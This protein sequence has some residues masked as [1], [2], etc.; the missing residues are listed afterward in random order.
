M[1][2]S[3]E[4]VAT[5]A[6]VCDACE[7]T[8]S[9]LCLAS[10]ASLRTQVATTQ[11]NANG[12]YRFTSTENDLLPGTAYN[13]VVDKSQAPLVGYVVT[14]AFQ[15]R[16]GGRRRRARQPL[17][18]SALVQA[19][20]S[21]DSNALAIGD[22]VVV[23]KTTA[24]VYEQRLVACGYCPVLKKMPPDA[25]ATARRPTGRSTSACA[26]NCRSATLFGSCVSAR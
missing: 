14:N 17:I 2:V 4:S 23:A 20:P 11:T 15:V 7:A 19:D 18:G 9:R 8:R 13:I 5:G 21:R 22:R 24:P 3:L 26:P 1:R 25:A 10:I 6:V 16:Q 12:I